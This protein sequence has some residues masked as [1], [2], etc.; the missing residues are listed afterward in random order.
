MGWQ[1]FTTPLQKRRSLERVSRSSLRNSPRIHGG[2]S[3][4]QHERSRTTTVWR[5]CQAVTVDSYGD[6]A[7]GGKQCARDENTGEKVGAPLC[8]CTSR[9]FENFTTT[10]LVLAAAAP[11]NPELYARDRPTECNCSCSCNNYSNNNKAGERRNEA[12]ERKN[13]VQQLGV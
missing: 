1:I 10:V 5:S 2:V 3:T 9:R 8:F 6:K 4:E 11:H 12:G 7:H 13:K